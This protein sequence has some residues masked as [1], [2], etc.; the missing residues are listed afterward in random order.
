VSLLDTVRCDDGKL[1][2]GAVPERFV[3]QAT[4][5]DEM[6][7]KKHETVP[8]KETAGP[9]NSQLRASVLSSRVP[10]Q[11][12]TRQATAPTPMDGC[13]SPLRLT[14]PGF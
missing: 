6:S 11:S 2:F 7:A 3:L 14:C 12:L 10:E 5:N 9:D 1:V 8:G 13:L 4:R